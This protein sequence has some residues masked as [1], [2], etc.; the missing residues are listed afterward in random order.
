MKFQLGF[1][2]E[3]YLNRKIARKEPEKKDNR[4]KNRFENFLL[5]E[6]EP[7]KISTPHGSK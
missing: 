4:R 1:Y 2:S 7:N 5:K 6:A 3:D